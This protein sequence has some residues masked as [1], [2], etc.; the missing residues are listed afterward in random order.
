MQN[1]LNDIWF[2]FYQIA[3]EYPI[4]YVIFGM[5]ITVGITCTIFGVICN[6]YIG[7]STIDIFALLEV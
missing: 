2:D 3:H 5:F 7:C 4:L 1:L 6:K